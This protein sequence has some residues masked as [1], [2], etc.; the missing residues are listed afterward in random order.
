MMI[1]YHKLIL[2]LSFIIFL[3]GI[4]KIKCIEEE[5]AVVD[6]DQ[7]A[8]VQDSFFDD[9][10]QK[11]IIDMGLDESS[12]ITRSQFKTFLERILF[13]EDELHEDDKELFL[14][15]IKN[16]VEEAPEEFPTKDIHTY[17]DNDRMMAKIMAIIKEREKDFPDENEEL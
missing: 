11:V 17:L 7:E 13:R 16:M 5:D 2:L 10:A 12:T 4:S 9:Y 1:K 14:L 15:L 8:E 3:S 6:D